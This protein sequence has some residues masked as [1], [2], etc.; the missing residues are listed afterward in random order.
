[1]LILVFHTETRDFLSPLANWLYKDTTQSATDSSGSNHSFK[2]VWY[3]IW[4]NMEQQLLE[5]T[6]NF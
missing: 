3:R 2:P 6:V 5:D 1:M 4:L